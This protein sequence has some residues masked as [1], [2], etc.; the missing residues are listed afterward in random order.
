MIS[1]D[2]DKLKKVEKLL[3]DYEYEKV[4]ICEAPNVYVFEKIYRVPRSV[5]EEIKKIYT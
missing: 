1:E 2:W 3:K 4:D 5:V